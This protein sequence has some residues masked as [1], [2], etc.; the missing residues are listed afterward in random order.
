MK[1][2]SILGEMHVQELSEARCC[3]RAAQT[4]KLRAE[5]EGLRATVKAQAAEKKALAEEFKALGEEL[6]EEHEKLCAAESEVGFI[7]AR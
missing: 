6:E 1:Q 5:L 7:K 2:I 4:E 3:V